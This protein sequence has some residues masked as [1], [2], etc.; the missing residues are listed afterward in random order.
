MHPF[1]ERIYTSLI[2]FANRESACLKKKRFL[3]ASRHPCR[4]DRQGVP[5]SRP[6][7]LRN[8]DCGARMFPSRNHDACAP[9]QWRELPDLRELHGFGCECNV[10]DSRRCGSGLRE[11][12]AGRQFG[13]L[14]TLPTPHLPLARLSSVS[15]LTGKKRDCGFK[16]SFHPVFFMRLLPVCA[17]NR[18]GF[19]GGPPGLFPTCRECPSGNIPPGELFRGADV[20]RP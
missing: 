20:R 1:A 14:R 9:F 15:N 19:P 16:K 4:M 2:I 11:P 7:R 5:V 18:A 13:Y 8:G 10:Q 17:Q 6:C 3:F 12:E